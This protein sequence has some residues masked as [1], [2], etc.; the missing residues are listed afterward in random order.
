MQCHKG[1]A[2]TRVSA[3][4]YSRVAHFRGC[5]FCVL[6]VITASAG[7]GAQ[8]PYLPPSCYC[9]SFVLSGKAALN[10]EGGLG[11]ES[12]HA[13]P[14]RP[15][16]LFVVSL[17]L[18]ALGS[19][20]K[21]ATEGCEMSRM[22]SHACCAGEFRRSGSASCEAKCAPLCAL[23][24]CT[25]LQLEGGTLQRCSADLWRRAE[26]LRG[27]YAGFIFSGLL[28]ELGTA[29]LN[30]PTRWFGAAPKRPSSG[31]LSILAGS[32]C[33]PPAPSAPRMQGK[34]R[35]GG[36]RSGKGLSRWCL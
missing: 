12:F 9:R 15:S 29:G 23:S 30:G 28:R 36:P 2:N 18:P 33:V 8:G 26:R 25:S 7:S 19:V 32:G 10:A 6:G 22:C 35:A 1:P 21:D 24:V 4:V 34:K 14:W 17:A 11:S 20:L 27:E 16:L 5:A 3:R 13:L 31:C